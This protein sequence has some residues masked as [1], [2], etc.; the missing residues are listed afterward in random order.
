[1]AADNVT[2]RA[3]VITMVAAT[4]ACSEHPP[5][6]VVVVWGKS[7]VDSAAPEGTVEPFEST[8]G[9]GVR[10]IVALPGGQKSTV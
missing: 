8:T 3:A 9:Q 2:S 5:A 7:L 10:V 6:K 4:E 1:M